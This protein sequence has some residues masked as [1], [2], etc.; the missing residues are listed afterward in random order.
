MTGFR[1]VDINLSNGSSSKIM[2]QQAGKLSVLQE[3]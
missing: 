2:I 1:Q 3:A